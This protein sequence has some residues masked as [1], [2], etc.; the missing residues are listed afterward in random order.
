MWTCHAFG[1]NTNGTY[2]GDSSGTGVTRS[3]MQWLKL[4]LSPGSSSLTLADHARVFDT[5]GWWYYFPSLM[6]N[7]AGDMVAG[8]SG[9]TATNY[10]SAFYTWRLSSGAVLGQPGVIQA[11][12]SSSPNRAGDY[13][14]TTL[15]P[16]DDWSFWTVQEYPK[17]VLGSARWGTVIGKIR[18][19]P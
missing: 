17:T 15:D 8:F 3:G 6:V 12:T 9:S 16:T 13:S 7:C 1:L 4:Q 18:P 10:V 11:G 19:N 5:N 14:A 2:T